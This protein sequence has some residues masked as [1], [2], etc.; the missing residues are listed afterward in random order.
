LEIS[1]DSWDAGETQTIVED[2]GLGYQ[3]REVRPTT[4]ITRIEAG[5]GPLEAWKDIPA[6]G[7]EISGIGE[8]ATTLTVP[9]EPATSVVEQTPQEGAQ[10]EHDAVRMSMGVGLVPGWSRYSSTRTRSFSNT[11]L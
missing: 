4:A 1:V 3:T 6:V 11:T 5:T 9:E 7:P 10:G 8:Y 2:R